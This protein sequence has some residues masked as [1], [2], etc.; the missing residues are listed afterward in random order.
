MYGGYLR[1]K[2]PVL[3][4]RALDSLAHGVQTH[5][6]RQQPVEAEQQPYHDE[7]SIGWNEIFDGEPVA[8]TAVA[9]SQ[10]KKKAV[11]LKPPESAGSGELAAP[12]RKAFWASEVLT[13]KK[14]PAYLRIQGGK[15]DA[16]HRDLKELLLQCPVSQ[17]RKPSEVMELEL[18]QMR[19]TLIE[20][21]KG[22]RLQAKR[23]RRLNRKCRVKGHEDLDVLAGKYRDSE[24][25]QALPDLVEK[26][27]GRSSKGV[28]PFVKD[29]FV[30]LGR[31]R[32]SSVV[33]RLPDEPQTAR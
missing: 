29:F 31:R 23:S 12:V 26:V 8:N 17:L 13:S 16:V 24:H 33:G 25:L 5:A 10:N 21:H 1:E 27:E 3:A 7:F 20:E 2:K 15:K 14:P 18:N 19:A 4:L 6:P 28:Q 11:D 9:R 22:K 32:L 30:E